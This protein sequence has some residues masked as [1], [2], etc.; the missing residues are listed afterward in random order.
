MPGLNFYSE[1]ENRCYEMTS[2]FSHSWKDSIAWNN[3]NISIL[4]ILFSFPFC[5]PLFPL[6]SLGSIQCNLGGAC[7]ILRTKGF[8]MASIE[9]KKVLLYQKFSFLSGMKEIKYGRG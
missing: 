3:L 4:S 9:D 1:R 7:C 5:T 8:F 2:S 6:Q